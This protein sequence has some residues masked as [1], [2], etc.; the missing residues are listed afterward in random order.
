M[1]YACSGCGVKIKD[2]KPPFLELTLQEP[3]CVNLHGYCCS[4]D[5]VK[6]FIEEW[7]AI[8][9]LPGIHHITKEQRRSQAAAQIKTI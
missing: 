4:D 7:Y 3:G 8:S 2:P 1:E 9:H 5:C 6:G